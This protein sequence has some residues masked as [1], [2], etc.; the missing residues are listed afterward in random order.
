MSVDEYRVGD[1]CDHEKA[2]TFSP[3]Q[4]FPSV[5]GVHVVKTKWRSPVSTCSASWCNCF[6]KAVTTVTI[7]ATDTADETV[8]DKLTSTLDLLTQS[9]VTVG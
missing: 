7:A 1:L 3:T 6:R 8:E 4:T 9:V 2:S 5:I